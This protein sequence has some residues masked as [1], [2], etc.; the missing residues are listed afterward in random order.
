M[1]NYKFYTPPVLADCLVK[2]LPQREYHKIVDICCGSWNLLEAA[3]KQFGSAY[4]VGVDVDEKAGENCFNE[5]IF[6]CEDGRKFAVAENRKYDL[7][8]SNPPFGYLTEDE[9]VF[10]N[11]D[12]SQCGI[13]TLKTKRYENEMMQA[14]LLLAEDGGV[15]LFI[16]PTTFL[17]GD[18]YL[19]TRKELCEK[20]SIDSIIKLPIETFGNSKISTFALIMSNSGKQHKKTKF[21]EIVSD[22][23]TWKVNFISDIS[24][25]RMR[26]GNWNGKSVKK[27]KLKD[28]IIYRGNISS[29]QMSQIGTKV[30]HSSSNIQDGVW[31]PSVR[32]CNDEK[33]IQKAKMVMPGD[34]IVNRVGRCARYWCISKSKGLVSDCLIVIQAREKSQLYDRMEKNSTNSQLNIDTKGVT[35]KYI[36]MRDVLDLL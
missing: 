32:Y 19:S 1:G 17:E 29:A 30:Y 2:L 22:G 7:V 35:T 9:R 26:E 24:A 27:N 14:N 16:L 28:V 23:I 8:L 15:L 25:T 31:K 33:V 5:A 34:I 10:N 12:E 11:F 20:Y 36:T 4:Y 21:Y 6:L 3:K 18:T 13:R